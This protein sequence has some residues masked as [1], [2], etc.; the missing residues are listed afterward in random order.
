MRASGTCS[1]ITDKNVTCKK[2]N[3]KPDNVLICQGGSAKLADLVQGLKKPG[4]DVSACNYVSGDSV[5]GRGD[6]G[7]GSIFLG[8]PQANHI[9]SHPEKLNG[10]GG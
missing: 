9:L 1:A 7:P 5:G 8:F 6:P 10:V 3:M 2:K 4:D